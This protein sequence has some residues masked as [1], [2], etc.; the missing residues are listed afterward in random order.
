MIGVWSKVLMLNNFIS[1]ATVAFFA[2]STPNFRVSYRGP[3]LK[4]EICRKSSQDSGFW[5]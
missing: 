3:A 4:K 2:L 5:S 1:R